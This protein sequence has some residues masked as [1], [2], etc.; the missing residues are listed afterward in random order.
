MKRLG[1]DEAQLREPRADNGERHEVS[2]DAEP[3]TLTA[4]REVDQ[5]NVGSLLP[6]ARQGPQI[7]QQESR[8]VTIDVLA[9]L[10]QVPLPHTHDIHSRQFVSMGPIMPQL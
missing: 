5:S 3:P 2:D 6:T 10:V 7:H 4:V 9:Y 8:Y 1:W